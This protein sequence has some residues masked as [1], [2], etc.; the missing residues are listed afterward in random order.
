MKKYFVLAF[1]ALCAAIYV[2]FFDTEEEKIP[3]VKVFRVGAECDYV[4]NSWVEHSPSDTNV[5]IAGTEGS[6]AEG[7]D[8]QIA[9]QVA[10]EI[11]IKLEI[12]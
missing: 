4:P 11:G 7:Y 3:D 10:H 9:K 12:H 1:I 6:Y 8:I 5:P 2:H